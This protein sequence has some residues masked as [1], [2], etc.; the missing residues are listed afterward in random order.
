[1][2]PA[3]RKSIGIKFSHFA[4]LQ[5]LGRKVAGCAHHA[6]INEINGLPGNVAETVGSTPSVFITGE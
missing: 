1:V 6:T 2:K 5:D 4:W 3:R